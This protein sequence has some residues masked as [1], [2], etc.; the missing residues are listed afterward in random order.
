MVAPWDLDPD[1]VLHS[2]LVR[3][4]RTVRLNSIEEPVAYLRRSIVNHINSEL[5]QRG[6]RRAAVRRLAVPDA[7]VD[8]YPS[9]LADLQR[10]Q[11]V[12]RAILYLHDVEGFGFDQV[13]EL[14]G[15]SASRVRMRASRAR[16]RLR[17]ALTEERET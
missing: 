8:H 11:P 9:D 13:A 14:F 1:D 15:M 10:L 17:K 5:R 16:S 2:A 4:L 12:D 7:A 6:T 3:V